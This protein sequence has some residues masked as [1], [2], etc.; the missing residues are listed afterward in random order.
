MN[1]DFCQ[2]CYKFKGDIAVS[3]TK[4]NENLALSVLCTSGCIPCLMVTD[5]HSIRE[6]IKNNDEMEKYQ[7]MRGH[8]RIE[9]FKDR[10]RHVISDENECPFHV[11][12]LMEE[13]CREEEEKS[14]KK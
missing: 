13:W 3:L 14:D 4:Y 11:E 2:K 7:S 6:I 10:I 9:L 12:L 8:R 1:L 5:L